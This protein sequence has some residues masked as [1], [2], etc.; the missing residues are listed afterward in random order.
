MQPVLVVG[1]VAFD[2]IE[3]PFGVAGRVVG[4]AATYFAVAAA[5]FT[6]VRMV[7]VV[8][9]DF[10][11]EQMGIF[12]GRRIDLTGL[13]QVPG[14]TFR[15]KGKYSEDLN[16]RESIYTFLNVFEEFQPNLP[17]VYRTSP[18]VFLGNIHPRLQLEVL[19]Q[20]ESPE[21]V[22]ADTM[23][24]WIEKTPEDLRQVLTRVDALVINDAEARQL[25]KESNLVKAVQ[26]LQTMGPRLLIIKRGEHGVLMFGP[27]GFFAVPGLPLNNVRDPTGAGDTF[28]GGLLGYLAECSVVNHDTLT[29]AVIA[30]STM[31]SFSVEAFGLERLLCV[32]SDEIQQRFLEFRRLTSFNEL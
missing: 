27:D 31:A 17:P 30:G 9:E 26:K 11:D 23:N 10:T 18:F 1:S 16:D 6:D 25:S 4:G 14:E 2:S 13:Q 7:A 32:T 20:V 28:G 24:Y 3:T 21:F 12:R 15:W 5:H 8:G 29:R 19:D 22:V